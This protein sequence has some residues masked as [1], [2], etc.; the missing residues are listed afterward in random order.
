MEK[1]LVFLNQCPGGFAGQGDTGGQGFQGR[2]GPGNGNA[3]RKGHG[4]M[5]M[6]RRKRTREITIEDREEGIRAFIE[7][8]K[9]NFTGR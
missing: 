2:N 1:I 6:D 9:P 3:D 7:R 8:R 4:L 5:R